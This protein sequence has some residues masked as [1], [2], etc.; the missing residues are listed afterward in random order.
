MRLSVCFLKREICTV[1][2]SN[3]EVRITLFL[4]CLYASK[5]CSKIKG[6]LIGRI[7]LHTRWLNANN[8]SYGKAWFILHMNA[9]WICFMSQK[10][11]I[12]IVALPKFASHSLSLEVW[13]GLNC[14]SYLLKLQSYTSCK[15]HFESIFVGTVNFDSNNFVIFRYS[16]NNSSKIDLINSCKTCYQNLCF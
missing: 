13:T 3:L 15:Q 8:K 4:F 2:F 16:S 11:H 9:N 6:S 5:F 14:I 1:T 7:L 10:Q 12:L